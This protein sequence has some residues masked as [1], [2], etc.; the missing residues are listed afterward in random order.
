MKKERKEKKAKREKRPI[1][2]KKLRVVLSII[3]TVAIIAGSTT[4]LIFSGLFNKYEFAVD[5]SSLGRPLPNVVNNINIW[6]IEGDPFANAQVT[7]DYNIFEFVEYV[8]FMQCSGGTEGRDLFVDPTDKT[9]LDDYDFTPLINNCRGVVN[10]GAKPFLKLGNVPLKYSKDASTEDGFG[11]NPYPPDDYDVYYNYIYAL[12]ESLVKEFGVEEVSTWRFGVMTE[13]ENWDWFHVKGDD[14]AETAKAYCM[15]YDY[16]VAALQDA[17]CDEVFVGAHSMTVT[18]GLW[19]EAEFIK[20]CA[21]GINYKTGKKGSRICYL[22]ASFYD[23][24]PNHYTDGYDLVGTINYL[25]DTAESVGLTDL[26]Y[27][28]DEGRILVGKN[29][30]ADTDELLTRTVGYT[31]QA[32]Y[33]ARLIA[34]MLE[35][36]INYFSAWSYLSNG[37]F[38][39]NPTVSYHVAKL[40]SAF[41][42]SKLVSVE[43][44]KKGVMPGTD[45]NVVAG[46]NEDTETL[47]LMSYNFKN[48]LNYNKDVDITMNINAPQFDGK[49]VTITQYV[50]GDDCNY[51]DDWV[52]DRETY[53]ITDDCFAWSPDDPEID[54]PITLRDENAR[55]IYFDELYDKYT[56]CSKLVPTE[57]TQKVTNSTITLNI[58]LKAHEVVVYEITVK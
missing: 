57:T 46:Y 41:Q 34:Q 51:F 19:D 11:L 15:L 9:V 16:T 7:G 56:E 52:K 14:P 10:L 1:N 22:S 48:K 27:G 26:I 25:R 23:S 12:A 17:I 37:F 18:E 54:N 33:D 8:Q 30:G 45:V 58:N 20:H 39:G 49:E 40:M 4:A 43:N 21:N 5:M 28:I 53:G 36:D 24:D 3:L 42:G 35:N 6:S 2:K 38:S 32:A 31:Y 13:Y 47:R 29:A 50:I 55:K 44:T